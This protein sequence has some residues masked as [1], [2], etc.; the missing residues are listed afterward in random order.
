MKEQRWPGDYETIPEEFAKSRM[1]E[2]MGLNGQN[3]S[4]GN[5]YLAMGTSVPF[6]MYQRE[7]LEQSWSNQLDTVGMQP[8]S[9]EYLERNMSCFRS[10]RK[11]EHIAGQMIDYPAGIQFSDMP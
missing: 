1:Q 11:F 7:E 3:M 10:D 2:Q 8:H 4:H 6:D 5:D 9:R